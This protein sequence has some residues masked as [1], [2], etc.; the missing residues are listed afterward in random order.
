[1]DGILTQTEH[2]NPGCCR[3]L[4][5]Q[6]VVGFIVIAQMNQMYPGILNQMHT[7]NQL[8]ETFERTV[9]G[10]G[11]AYDLKS[12]VRNALDRLG[13]SE[14]ILHPVDIVRFGIYG[15]LGRRNKFRQLFFDVLGG[16]H[17][18]SYPWI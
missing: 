9:F 1:M 2:M 6:L 18:V 16:T 5:G 8:P 14:S 3:P 11:Q 17:H 13:M 7:C 10:I 15:H 4:L 12:I